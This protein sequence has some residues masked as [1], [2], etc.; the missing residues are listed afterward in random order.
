VSGAAERD[1]FAGHAEYHARALVFGNRFLPGR[2]KRNHP[3]RPVTAHSGGAIPPPDKIV[4]VPPIYPGVAK[5]ARLQGVVDVEIVVGTTRNVEQARVVRSV[6]S[7]DDA[8]LTAIRQ[9]KYTPTI[10]N[11]T[12]VPILMKV[13]VAF[14]L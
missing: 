4:D 6:P 11:G 12:A 10:I 9:C 7:L 8:A 13:H 14:T 3:V 5:T 1:G 2:A